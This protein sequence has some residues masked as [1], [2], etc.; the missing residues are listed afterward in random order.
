MSE[1]IETDKWNILFENEDLLEDGL[2]DGYVK[3]VL[4]IKVKE[5][6]RAISDNSFNELKQDLKDL[7][8]WRQ[9]K[10]LRKEL[11]GS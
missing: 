6:D 1:I 8:K 11:N 5:R 2:H 10:Q 3:V 4:R 9:Y 7:G